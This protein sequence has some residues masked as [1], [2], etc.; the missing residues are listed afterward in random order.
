MQLA[1]GLQEAM[2]LLAKRNRVVSASEPPEALLTAQATVM[3]IIEAVRAGGDSSLKFYTQKFDK[4]DLKTVEVD[5]A[6]IAKAVS[7]TPSTLLDALEVASKRIRAFH[8]R[9]MPASWHDNAE[10]YGEKFTPVDRA[11]IY[12]PGGS[13]A[14]P[15]SVLMTVIPAQVAG[16]SEII[17]CTPANQTNGPDPAVLAA[18]SLCGV[19]RV[20]AVGGAQAIAAMAYGTESI[21]PVDLICG[22][23]NRYVT[24]AKKI[25][26]GDVGI[27]GLYGPT[28][29]IVIADENADPRYCA[30]DLLAQAEHDALAPPILV[31]TS[32]RVLD[33]VQEQLH[34]QLKHL[35]RAHIAQASLENNGLLI[36]VNSI[37]EALEI[38]NYFAPE[39]LCL[40]V[41]SPQDYIPLVRNAG[42]LFLG[43]ETPEVLGD[44]VA[45]PSHVMPTG[46][47]ARFSSPL[48]VHQFLKVTSTIAFS[49][50]L[51]NELQDITSTIAKYEGF[52]AHATAVDIR[53]IDN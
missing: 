53:T 45:G 11:G 21:S 28:E 8:E 3:E 48:G 2:S 9:S 31:T 7:Q 40:L 32:E 10:G 20:F 50:M 29:T 27:D 16:V 43:H 25:V 17:V 30:A 36:K 42:A 24:L 47:T 33:A 22:P 37:T 14:Y 13:A 23:G 26:Y 4:V 34:S 12:I 46:G 35:S 38:A 52:T 49:D 6:T 1:N 19:D 51:L 41:D 18:C 39:H 5:E 44:F 15:S